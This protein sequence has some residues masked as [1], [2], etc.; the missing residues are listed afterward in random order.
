[1]GTLRSSLVAVALLWVSSSMAVAQQPTPAPSD[2][3][4][5]VGGRGVVTTGRTKWSVA[6][7]SGSPN[8]LSELRWRG[9]DSF[10]A[11]VNA[12]VVWKR[13]VLLGSLGGGIVNQGVLIDEDFA[14]DDRQGQ[15][16][17]TRSDVTGDGLFYMNTDVGLRVFTWGDPRTPASLGYVDLF[18]GYQYWREEYEASGAKGF[19][20][21]RN[22]PPP[23]VPVGIPTSVEVIREEF[24]WQSL[25]V[26]GR[27]R[28]PVYRGLAAKLSAVILPWSYSR[29][30]DVHLLRSDLKQDPSFVAEAQGGFG[31]QLDAG[32]SYSVWRGLSAE[33]GFRYWR[34]D[35]GDG[36]TVAR[37]VTGTA[38]SRLNEIIIERYGPYVGVTYRFF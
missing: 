13:I 2:L 8:V 33:A 20:P 34:I 29:L 38:K 4:F 14:L 9:V 12:E 30:E 35:S 16:G 6:D 19:I 25:R 32:L 27:A 21:V 3:S 36:D 28:V 7:S 18:V 11:E 22:P 26:G 5:T 24:T 10:V 1:M 15:T 17:R 23:S 31:V 37:G